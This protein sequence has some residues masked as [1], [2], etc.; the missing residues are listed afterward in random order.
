MGCAGNLAL[1]HLTHC[2]CPSVVSEANGA[3][4]AMQPM[5]RAPQVAWSEAEGQGHRGRLLFAY[6]LLAKQEKVSRGVGV[7]P[8]PPHLDLP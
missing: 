4:C 1:Q 2:A 7:K 3:S 8:P 5:A 6:F